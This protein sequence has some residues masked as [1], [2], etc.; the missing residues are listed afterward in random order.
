MEA[1]KLETRAPR[2]LIADDDPAIVRLLAGRCARAGFDVETATNGVQAL[3]KASRRQPDIL[4]IDVNM[5]EADGLTICARLLD[6]SKKALNVVVITGSSETETI[7]RCDGFGAYYVRKGSDFWQGLSEAL[8]ETFPDMSEQISGLKPEPMAAL[9]KSRPRILVIDEDPFIEEFLHSRLGK[10]SVDTLHSPNAPQ[11]Y[12]TACREEPSVIICDY[13]MTD[14]DAHY[15]LARLRTTRVTE[16]IPVFVW[17]DLDLTETARQNLEREVC[18]HPGAAGIFKKTI[19]TDEL[20]S[21]LQKVVGF[22]SFDVTS[23][24]PKSWRN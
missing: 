22:D 6:P 23:H 2:M 7:A 12:R 19:E 8:T 17:T 16:N 15:L 5:P 18:G 20:F 24:A 21:T 10:F 13:A 3:I 1:Q 11:G 9:S 14:G 4:I